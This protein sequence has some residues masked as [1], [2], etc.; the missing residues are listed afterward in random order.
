[1]KQLFIFCLLLIFF[2]C[3]NSA[4]EKPSVVKDSITKAEAIPPPATVEVPGDSAEPVKEPVTADVGNVSCT[5]LIFFQPGAEIESVSYDGK[6]KENSRQVTRILSVSEKG[7]FTVAKVASTDTEAG[8][9]GKQSKVFYDYKCDGKNI[10]FDI[11][12][13]FRTE[14]KNSDSSF[15]STPI[16]FPISVK[17]G[18]VL[19][20]AKGV[21]SAQRGDRKMTMTYTFK[22]RK[23]EA[24]EEITTPAG[25]WK[26]YK[27]SNAVEVEMDIPGMEEKT[28][29]MMKQMQGIMK[30]TSSTW[31]SPEFGIVR[32][33]TYLNGEMKSRNEVVSFKKK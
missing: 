7:G 10:Y 22:K 20:D 4:E 6:G 11:A 2:S 9:K 23:V 25:T 19:P 21:M 18:Q 3:N 16:P 33:E 8:E 31:L 32:M 26:C 30:M 13:M 12:S 17:A 5:R 29:A 15:E 14:K 28:K 1:M 27:I 24:M